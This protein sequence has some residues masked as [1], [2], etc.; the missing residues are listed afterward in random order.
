MIESEEERLVRLTDEQLRLLDILSAHERVVVQGVAGSGKTM[1]ARTQAARFAEA[2]RKTLFLCYN[3]GLAG[4]VEQSLPDHLRDRIT[5]RH[6]HRL[7]NEKA[8]EAGLPFD[9]AMA[10]D[11]NFWMEIAPEILLEG[12]SATE[13]RFDAIVVDEGQDFHPDWWLPIESINAKGE[14]GP[15]YIFCDPAQNLFIEGESRYPVEAPP[16]NLTLNCRNTKNIASTCSRI[17]GVSIATSS[18]APDGTEVKQLTYPN[19]KEGR[20]IVKDE[21]DAWI[22]RGRLSS[23]QVAIMTPVKKEKTILE[24]LDSLGP[25]KLTDDY[26]AWQAGM[27]ILVTTIRAFKGLE[28]DAVILLD[29]QEIERSSHMSNADYYVGCSRAK[30]LLT[31]AR[32]TS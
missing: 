29:A 13:E 7:C 22:K 14:G 26:A 15:L 25:H 19:R 31:V 2:G 30:H 11:R 18:H 27:G 3:K 8:H 32:L 28:A 9:P 6:F 5:V 10:G 24:G 1:L 23:A 17:L 4:W 21:L 20:Q 16:L 12:V